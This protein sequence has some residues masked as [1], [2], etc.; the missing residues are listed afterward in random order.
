M[1]TYITH[2]RQGDV[3]AVAQ[4]PV[5]SRIGNAFV[6]YV[7]YLKDFVW[8]SNLAVFYPYLE[9]PLWLTLLAALAVV[10]A[11]VMA[12]RSIRR[13]PYF[14]VGWFWYLG[15]LIPMIGLIQAG[16]QARADRY[17]YIP[18]I[19]ISIV[20]AWG[21]V[22]L[23]EKRGWSRRALTIA[24]VGVCAAWTVVTW[25]NVQ[26]WRNSV[27]LF[28]N[29]LEVT[30]AN[31]VAYHNLGVA[32]R[33]DGKIAEAV[34]DFAHAVAILPEDAQLQDS[35]GEA[36]TDE[37]RIDDATPHLLQAVRLRPDYAKAHIDLGTA[38]LRQER[39]AEAES[40]FRMAVQLQ[41]DNAAAQYGLGGLLM[42]EGIEQEAKV[43]LQ[44]ALPLLRA[45]VELNPQGVDGH[46]NL[47][48]LYGI[49]GRP[50]E[51]ILEFSQ[52]IRLRPG[53]AQARFNLGTA[54]AAKNRLNEAAEQF[55]AATQLVPDY[56][57]AYFSL[58]RVQ[59]ALGHEMEAER[60]YQEAIRLNPGLA[61]R[62]PGKSANQ[63]RPLP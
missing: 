14:S 30:D 46:Y 20:L 28:T 47:G 24:A 37:G 39:K 60:E 26:Y 42:S 22:E 54:L 44:Q 40:Q 23:F 50:D 49:L 4:I 45:Q 3:V 52:V 57:I 29:A 56:A 10:A 53:D 7:T 33:E 17:T 41:P 36:L 31:Y 38:L 43:H 35:L 48:T 19:G 1:V 6:S 2:Q 62:L 58:A 21:A 13:R 5:L 59:A 32:L 61:E 63:K 15:A 18:S 11:T 12:A 34:D 27:A 9:H 25:V 55:A 51:A 16:S 8:P